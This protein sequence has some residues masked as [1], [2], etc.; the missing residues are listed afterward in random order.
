[1]VS[2]VLLVIDSHEQRLHRSTNTE[3]QDVNTADTS[4][5]R[6]YQRVHF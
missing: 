6:S 2:V 4:Y 3:K 1:M 5:P